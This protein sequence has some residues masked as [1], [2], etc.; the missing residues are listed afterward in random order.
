MAELFG[1]V[2]VVMI[3]C[4]VVVA[5]GTGCPNNGECPSRTTGVSHI[6]KWSTCKVTGLAIRGIVTIKYFDLMKNRSSAMMHCRAQ[7]G[8]LGILP[9][10]QC[11]KAPIQ[12]GLHQR[13]FHLG[14]HSCGI[15][16]N[17][18]QSITITQCSSNS[19]FSF[20]C[21]RFYPD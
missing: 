13:P 14:N 11:L 2:L 3:S 4:G 6:Q 10:K 16:D 1:I 21:Q 18:S 12:P 9:G 20:F 8:I 7:N 19:T 5:T 15:Y 17:T